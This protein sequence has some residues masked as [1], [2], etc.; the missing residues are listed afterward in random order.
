MGELCHTKNSLRLPLDLVN[1]ISSSPAT[2]VI[3]L[4]KT[5]IIIEICDDEKET[6]LE[7]PENEHNI[8]DDEGEVDIVKI[9]NAMLPTP[10]CTGSMDS[11]SSSSASSSDRQ[12]S[13]TT[14]GKHTKAVNEEKLMERT[15]IVFIDDLTGL[16]NENNTKNLNEVGKA[17]YFNNKHILGVV[18]NTTRLSDSTDEDSGFENI[19]KL[20]K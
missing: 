15:S 16:E 20:T 12:S 9:N 17:L 10:S 5:E 4:P 14:F 18:G 7:H 2:D 13:F 8:I 11:L 3:L 19:S 1:S 6:K